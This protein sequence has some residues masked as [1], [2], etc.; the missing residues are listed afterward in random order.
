MWQTN[1]QTEYL[2]IST[3][4]RHGSC[5]KTRAQVQLVQ[6]R[7]QYRR[8]TRKSIFA[9]EEHF[10]HSITAAAFG[11]VQVGVGADR[12]S[13]SP[14]WNLVEKARLKRAN[15]VTSSSH[16]SCQ[17]CS[18]FFTLDLSLRLINS[19]LYSTRSPCRLT[20]SARTTRTLPFDAHF[21]HKL[22][23]TSIKHSSYSCVRPD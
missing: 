8:S 19:T 5:E 2:R 14:D 17:C 21:Y 10:P 7:W 23:G 6:W 16:T 12:K 1:G 13:Q 20:M 22:M 9:D 4:I 11:A 15:C 3:D 18:T